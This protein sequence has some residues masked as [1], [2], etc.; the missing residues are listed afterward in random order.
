[1]QG[2]AAFNETGGIHSCDILIRRQHGGGTAKRC[3]ARVCVA[4]LRTESLLEHMWRKVLA[5]SAYLGQNLLWQPETEE[6]N[7]GFMPMPCMI[8]GSLWRFV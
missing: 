6:E 5:D 8:V 2:I 7:P 4:V 1:M 3:G